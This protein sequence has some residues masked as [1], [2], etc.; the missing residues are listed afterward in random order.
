M[1]MRELLI[2]VA[3]K[4]DQKA[5]VKLHVPG[6]KV[7]R[8]VSSRTTLGGPKNWIIL[9]YG[10]KGGAAHS[11]WIGIYDPEINI[12]ATTGLYL[13]YIFSM[14]LKTVTLTLQQG[15]TD[16]EEKIAGLKAVR[17]HLEW[18]AKLLYDSLPVALAE[19]W[20]H[21]PVFGK[22][23]RPKLYESASVLA[24]AY[25]TDDMP[26]EEVLQHD[27]HTA[28]NLLQRVAAADAVW[29]GGEDDE[30]APISQLA[31][32][33]TR[34]A[35][36]LAGFKPRNSGEY[37]VN[38]AARQQRK[39]RHHEAVITDFAAYIE[40]RDYTVENQK[41]HPKDLVLR[42]VDGATADAAEWLVEVKVVRRG[43][44]TSAVREA[45]GQLREYSYF[46]YREK[47]LPVPHLLA[48]FSEDIGA[49][50]SY[51]EDQGIAAIWRD[52]EGWAG[53]CTAAAWGMVD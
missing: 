14:D 41:I 44:P 19:P 12:K 47:G 3:Q 31:G 30:E 23:M 9:G 6:Q 26:A 15:V 46:H 42:H 11:P 48:L 4:Y 40:A 53:S 45:V 29:R 38:I 39:T 13:A 36:G 24:R 25:A 50:A 1:T 5:G 49:Y 52:G 18:Q 43:N 2:E 10:G 28:A 32:E 34:P 16:L 35:T 8:S 27:L 33:A 20:N 51:L 22:E 7:L 21:R 37:L 17:A